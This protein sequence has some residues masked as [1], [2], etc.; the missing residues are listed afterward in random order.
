MS[1]SLAHIDL[2]GAGVLLAAAVIA[3]LVGLRPLLAAHASANERAERF[4]VV[5]ADRAELERLRDAFR[6][7]VEAVERE[8]DRPGPKLGRPSARNTDVAWV[9]ETAAEH[10]LRLDRV[11]PGDLVTSDLG[12]HAPLG[13]EGQGPIDR[14]GDMLRRVRSDRP[15]FDLRALVLESPPPAEGG[16][17]EGEVRFSLLFDWRTAAGGAP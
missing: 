16:V 2:G 6:V 12:R 7:Q 13:L 5:D 14:V 1:R 17:P 11:A 10:G 8:A 9:V 3:G 4:A 15:A